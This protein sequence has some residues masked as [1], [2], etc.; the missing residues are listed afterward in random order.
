MARRREQL[1]L[2]DGSAADA[3]RML[4]LSDARFAELRPQLTRRG[5]PLP[6]QD[7]GLFDLD[8]V[9]AWR[10]QRNP[11]LFTEATGDGL[12]PKPPARDAQGVVGERIRGMSRGKREDTLLRG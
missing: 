4:G 1:P 11:H 6:D 2:G 7:T 12:T 8:A 5:F 3:A 9:N 10:R